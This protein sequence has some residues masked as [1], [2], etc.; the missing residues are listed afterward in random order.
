MAHPR[1]AVRSLLHQERL[2]MLQIGQVNVQLF[3]SNR[4]CRKMMDI[5]VY[6]EQD[7][8]AETAGTILAVGKLQL[9][10]LLGSKQSDIFAICCC[11]N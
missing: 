3:M 10:G 11:P 8:P 7:S 4:H 5:P 2:V 9:L 6:Q 1:F